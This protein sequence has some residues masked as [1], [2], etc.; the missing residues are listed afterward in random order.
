MPPKRRL[1]PLARDALWAAAGALAGVAAY[2]MVPPTAPPR[3]TVADAA[4]AMDAALRLNPDGSWSDG[5]V[6]TRVYDV[7]DLLR[8]PDGR[9]AA[10]DANDFL[11][12]LA[13]P[14][15]GGV[16]DELL[17]ALRLLGASGQDVPRL[18]GGRLILSDTATGH[19]RIAA[20]L[21]ALRLAGR[22]RAVR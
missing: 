10:G 13:L 17:N 6:Q 16:G 14:G 9:V 19:T 3:A 12:D 11:T 2:L 20:V 5:P 4:A 7:R 8:E 15:T 22:A 21:D 1:P 18:I